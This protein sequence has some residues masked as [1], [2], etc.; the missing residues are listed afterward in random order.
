MFEGMPKK[1]EEIKPIDMI[2]GLKCIYLLYKPI[3]DELFKTN[4]AVKIF[5]QTGLPFWKQYANLL[6]LIFWLMENYFKIVCNN[7]FSE[8]INPRNF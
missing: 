4:C 3:R 2:F 8:N 1:F 5:E 6:I 7:F